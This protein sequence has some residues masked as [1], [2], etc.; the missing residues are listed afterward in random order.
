MLFYHF[1]SRDS[2]QVTAANSN[3]LFFFSLYR[4]SAVIECILKVGRFKLFFGQFFEFDD[5]DRYNRIVAVKTFRE[6]T[7]NTEEFLKEAA[8]MK[9]IKHP[10]L[11]QLLGTA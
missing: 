6:D 9:S 5:F 4:P 2:S 10:N 3:R 7:T 11:V 8:V 1:P